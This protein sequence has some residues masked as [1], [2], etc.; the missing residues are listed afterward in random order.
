MGVNG[1]L[2]FYTLQFIPKV[3]KLCLEGLTIS[4]FADLEWLE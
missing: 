2:D 3:N 4:H 1:V